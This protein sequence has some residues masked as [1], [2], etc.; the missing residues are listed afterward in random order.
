M[1]VMTVIGRFT[2]DPELKQSAANPDVYFLPFSLAENF[3]YKDNSGVNFWECIAFG[4]TAQH[5]IKAK[6]QKGSLIMMTCEV[7]QKEYKTKDD[8]Q[9]KTLDCTVLSWSYI[10][11][12]KEKTTGSVNNPEAPAGEYDDI[13][14]PGD[15]DD[16]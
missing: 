9:V 14:T 13:P 2:K 12:T 5:M 4:E 16:F 8:T 15:D 7:K 11:G 3:G 6:V 10:P 1:A